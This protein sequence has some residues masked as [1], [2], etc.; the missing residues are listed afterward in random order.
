MAVPAAVAVAAVAGYR[1]DTL[2]GTENLPAGVDGAAHQWVDLD[3]EGVAGAL[4]RLPG[5]WLYKPNLGGGR[6][7][8]ATP[9]ARVP[10]LAARPGAGRQLVDLDGDGRLDLVDLTDGAGSQERGPDG[11]WGPFRPFRS[12]PTLWWGDGTARFADVTGDGRP[13]ILHCTADALSWYRSLGQDG[14]AAGGRVPWAGDEERGPR[15]LVADGEHALHLADVSGDGLPDLVRIGNGEV[16]YWPNLGYGRFGAKVEMANAPRFDRPDCFDAAR[17]RLADTDGSG[18]TDLVYLGT[19]GVRVY[20]NEAGNAWSDARAVPAPGPPGRDVSV[21]V[22]DLLGRGT[23]CLVWSSRRPADARRP[24]R[25][26]DLA[27]GRKPHLLTRLHN[28]LGS[29]TVL[30]YASSTELYLADKAAGRPWLTRLPFPVHVVRQVE[31]YDH[32]G[33]NRFVTRYSYRHGYFDGEEREFRGFARV[34]QQDTAEFGVL[35]ATGALPAGANVDEASHVPPVLTRTWHHTGAFVGGEDLSRRLAEEYHREPGDGAVLDGAVLP[36]GLTPVECREA[37]RALKGSVLR[38]EVYAADGGPAADRPYLVTQRSYTVRKL[39]PGVFLPHPR[40]TVEAHYERRRYAVGGQQTADPRTGHELILDVDDFGTVLLSAS[41]AYGRRFGDP[42]PRLTDRDRDLQARTTVVVSERTPTAPVSAPHA[43]RGP[44]PA[45]TSTYE[46]LNVAPAGRRFA[47]AELRALIGTAADL[48]VEDVEGSGVTGAGAFRRLLGRERTTYR[49]ND[50]SGPLA[51]GS[52]DTLCLPDA[53]H[54]LALTP[55][56]M[57]AVFPDLPATDV[58][59]VLTG[60]GGFVQLAGEDGWWAPSAR[61]SY[62]TGAG[63]D[64]ATELA[65]A[66]AH[67]FRGRRWVDPFGSPTTVGYDDHDLLVTETEDA[68]GNVAR[69]A[70]DYRVLQPA[71]V[72]DANGNRRAAAFDALGH[73]VATA[74]MGKPAEAVGDSLAGVVADL[75]DAAVAAHLADPLTGG[76]GLLGQA[77]SRLVYD[78]H[79]F[80]RAGQPAVVSTL[81]RRLHA[82]DAGGGT[83]EV[84]ASLSYRDGSGEEIQRREQAEDGAWAVTGWTILD[85]KRNVVRRYE[86]FLDPDPGFAFGVAVGVGTTLC[87]DPLGRVVAAVQPDHSWRKVVFDAWRQETWDGNDT[88]LVADPA[89]D[90]DVG[91]WFRRLPAALYLPTWHAARAGGGIGDA[92]RDAAVKAAAHAA[93]PALAAVDPRGRVFLGV[94][95][96]RAAGVDR[97]CRTRL[98]LD[99][100]GVVRGEV[101]ARDRLVARTEL[102]LLGTRLAVSSMDAGRRRWLCDVAG[103]PVQLRD[104]RGHVLTWTYDA[105]RRPLLRTVRGTDPA[106]SDPLTLARDVVYERVEYGEGRPDASEK[107]LRTRIAAH[108]DGAGVESFEYDFKGNVVAATRR[109]T[110]DHRGIPDWAGSPALEPDAWRHGATFDALDRVTARTFPDGSATSVTYSPRGLVVGVEVDVRGAGTATPFAGPVEYDARGAC[111]LL[112]LGNGA[113]TEYDYDPLT[114]RTAG[115]IT[116][117]PPSGTGVSGQLFA[118]A[119]RVQDLRY[120]YDPGGNVTRVADAAL[121]PVFFQNAQVLPVTS[122]T[123]DAA[124]RLVEAQGR[125]HAG[126]TAFAAAGPGG[127]HRDHPF[128][129]VAALGDPGA[130]RTYVETFGYDAVGNLESVGHAAGAGSWTRTYAYGEPSRLDSTVSGNRLSSTSTGAGTE[131]YGYDGHGSVTAM[132]HLPVLEWDFRGR[133]RTSS[134]QVVTGPAG[135]EQTFYQYAAAGERVR[136]VTER[137]AGSRLAERRSVRGNEVHREYGGDGVTVTAARDTLHV[138]IGDR[139]LA[140][141]ETTPGAP[142]GPV[143]VT[144]YQFGDQL[145]S[146]TVELDAAGQLISYEQFTA[147]GSPAY[148]AGRSAAEVSLKRYRYTGRE[149]DDE[150]GLACHGARYY[151]P[152]LGRWTACDP[153]GTADGPNLYQYA[154]SNPVR[155]RDPGGRQAEDEGGRTPTPPSARAQADGVPGEPAAP[156][157]A[158][159]GADRPGAGPNAPPAGAG[160]DGGAPE[161]PGEPRPA[162]RPAAHLHVGRGLSG[163]TKVEY[164][165]WPGGPRGWLT[166]LVAAALIVPAALF[167]AFRAGRRTG[168][169]PGWY[170]ALK[171]GATV[172]LGV[173]VGT[174]LA[175]EHFKVVTDDQSSHNDASPVDPYWTPIHTFTGVVMGLWHVP[176]P[177]V[178]AATLLWEVVEIV[179]PGFG[180]KEINANRM[181]DIGVAWAGWAVASGITSYLL[182]VDWAL[183]FRGRDYG[184]DR[185]RARPRV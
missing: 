142:A 127:H 117:R 85:N 64:A 95:H 69:A 57:T 138:E 136:V 168:G 169:D 106:R 86:P 152:W 82:R 77:T 131:S 154:Q 158:G 126:Q 155:M 98:L 29:E 134:R 90:P 6:L 114:F 115:V 28:G 180:D 157:P 47:P 176:F 13:D 8:P 179:A 100:S 75:T 104:G 148:Q 11:D 45:R 52:A 20:L 124:Y 128:A 12:W 183:G 24:V 74:A 146:A 102:D 41:V 162:D 173:W 80:V 118:D 17:L 137:A 40:E 99:V 110:A 139:R 149:R 38:R 174:Q 130:V 140:L 19:D 67:F 15:V 55:G 25:Y 141:V 112:E 50:L 37:A 65:E 166:I 23:A 26:L 163:V 7:G 185:S 71:T 5:E 83:S 60:P 44:M 27:A 129:G 48:P 73:V 3:G 89:A 97:F 59:G 125:E 177:V 171:I 1:I 147:Y 87:H 18:T 123:Y 119:T 21:D 181:T 165:N 43:W 150:T 94:V 32:V 31:T 53:T 175:L 156:A 78:L 88:V 54:R 151:A 22:T 167:I 84:Y 42:D 81:T 49:R 132:P 34:D 79:A 14:F 107:N 145:G 182:G 161:R 159:A 63:D 9:V 111:R 103:N 164:A 35:T 56:L 68:L 58:A 91:G 109:F 92:E 16:C 10:A 121:R 62:S 46:L 113:R 33:R 96:D 30:G 36:P 105:L 144:R 170:N 76:L 66:V 51:S 70:N 122:Y 72:T 108:R 160:A 101:D 61:V 184:P 2:A 93:T 178:A 172:A 153:A 120:T 135:R 116:T 4:A 143:S 39:A 133:L